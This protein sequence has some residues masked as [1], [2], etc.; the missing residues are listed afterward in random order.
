MSDFSI[1]SSFFFFVILF[2]LF[3]FYKINIKKEDFSA[4]LECKISYDQTL[5]IYKCPKQSLGLS[6]VVSEFNFYQPLLRDYY[7]RDLFVF[8]T[9]PT[10]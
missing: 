4:S 6:V 2:N 3:T 5:Y 8:G 1:L 10:H 7:L 9:G